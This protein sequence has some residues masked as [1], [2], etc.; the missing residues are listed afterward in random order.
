MG[1]YSKKRLPNGFKY[2]FSVK[3][4]KEIEGICQIKFIRV[5]NGNV[6]STKKFNLEKVYP[7]K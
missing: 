6:W 7:L 3:E 1:K 5:S 2:L 4:T